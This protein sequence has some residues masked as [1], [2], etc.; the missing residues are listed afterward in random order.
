MNRPYK[1]DTIILTIFVVV[2]TGKKSPSP[3]SFSDSP[4]RRV[5]PSF[6]QTKPTTMTFTPQTQV[7]YQTAMQAYATNKQPN[8][9]SQ[10]EVKPTQNT[11]QMTPAQQYQPR[12]VEVNLNLPA[13]P[14]FLK[15][16]QNVTTQPGSK[17]QFQCMVKCSPD[18][19]VKWYHNGTL[20]PYSP[21]CPANFDKLTGL[22]TLTINDANPHDAGQYTCVASNPTGQDT[23]TAWAVVRG[24][25]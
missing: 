2:I 4:V 21:R 15:H 20:I 17:T 19:E 11:V 18:T 9:Y 13:K 22:A 23:S 5:Q 6:Y 14:Q 25:Y 10:T 12:P 8:F 24:I 7:S 16:L 1:A 3:R